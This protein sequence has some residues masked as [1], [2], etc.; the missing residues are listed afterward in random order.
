MRRSEE[1]NLTLPKAIIRAAVYARYSS[2]MQSSS[3]ARDQVERIRT[4][5]EKDQIESRLHPGS[6]VKIHQEW[7]QMDEAISGKLAGRRGY[8]MILDGI[9]RKAFELVIVDDLSRLTRSLGNLLDLYQLLR[10]HDIELI[11]ISDRVSSADPNAR[12]FFTVKGMVA[13]FGNEAH[14]ERTLRGLEARAREGFS[15][16]QKPYGYGSKAEKSEK[17]KGREV[18]SHFKLYIIPEQAE[19]VRRVFKIYSEGF[20]KKYIA[21]LFNQEKVPTPKLSTGWKE[22]IIFRMLTQEKYTGRWI[23]KKT[24][25]SV[26]PDSN[27]KVPK[28]RPR[29]EWIS[30]QREELRIIDQAL[31]EKVQRILAEN[32]RTKAAGEKAETKIFGSRNRIDNR[33][34]LSGV[35]TCSSCGMAMVLVS[36][37]HDGYYGCYGA[38]RQGTC[39]SKY[40]IP[41]LKVENAFLKTLQDRLVSNEEIIRY[42]TERYNHAVK[43]IMASAPNRKREVEVQ[44]KKL[45]AEIGNLVRFIAEGKASDLETISSAVRERED[46]KSRLAQEFETLAAAKDETRL[47]ITPHLVK[48]SFERTLSKLTARGDRFNEPIKGLLHGPML[49][50]KEKGSILVNGAFDLGKALSGSTECRIAL[51]PGFEPGFLP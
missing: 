4:L 15:A 12:T 14:S 43:G 27:R 49:V 34:L 29:N 11:S 28:P 50:R 19:V 39:S 1:K 31:W 22:G 17:R 25:T 45:D 40:L 44:L 20:G 8:Q 42:A 48:S 36:G 13:D 32:K 41:R 21:K 47:L 6:R 38:H 23:Y 24:T 9:R 51:P 2:E 35:L 5:A 46:Q 16:G 33:H 18:P 26:D 3:S 7:V 37:R 10:H 30:S